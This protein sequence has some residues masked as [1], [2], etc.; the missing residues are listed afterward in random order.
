M[1]RIRTGSVSYFKCS[2][3]AEMSTNHYSDFH[4]SFFDL[5]LVWPSLCSVDAKPTHDLICTENVATTSMSASDVARRLVKFPF[6]VEL[7]VAH[8][9][10]DEAHLVRIIY[11]QGAQGPGRRS[12]LFDQALR[13]QPQDHRMV[14]ILKIRL[15]P[16][17]PKLLLYVAVFTGPHVPLVS[18]Q[19]NFL[20]QTTHLVVGK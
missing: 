10:P 9:Y 15:L 12:S 3:S 13:C 14:R 18:Q 16:V 17:I 7:A 1:I 5:H 8:T 2:S 11:L 20:R 19:A 6:C 4:D